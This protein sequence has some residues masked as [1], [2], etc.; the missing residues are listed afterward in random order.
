[1]KHTIFLFVIPIVSNKFNQNGIPDRT[2]FNA[3]FAEYAE[4]Q[5]NMAV[6]DLNNLSEIII[7]KAIAVIVWI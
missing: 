5:E 1:M 3:E 6:E 7:G 4:E 2:I